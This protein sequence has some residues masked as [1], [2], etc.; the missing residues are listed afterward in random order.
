[1]TAAARAAFRAKWSTL[2]DP[3]GEL[4]ENERAARAD[5]ALR[6]HMLRLAEL[7]AA[8]RRDRRRGQGPGQERAR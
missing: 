3:R 7:S 1:M 4:D 6:A 8:R 2:V 5:R